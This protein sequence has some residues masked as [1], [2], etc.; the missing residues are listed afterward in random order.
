V[1]P[2]YGWENNIATRPDQKAQ[3]SQIILLKFDCDTKEL[4]EFFIG[5]IKSCWGQEKTITGRER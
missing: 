4:T 1:D 2:L 3:L 5:S